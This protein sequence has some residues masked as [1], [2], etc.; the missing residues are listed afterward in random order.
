MFL[1]ALKVGYSNR[2][3][4][5]HIRHATLARNKDNTNVP[6]GLRSPAR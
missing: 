3:L 2:L 1:A 5:R 4:V 6:E